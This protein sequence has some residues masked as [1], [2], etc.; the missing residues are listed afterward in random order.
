[1]SIFSEASNYAG[2]PVEEQDKIAKELVAKG[3]KVIKL[4]RGDPAVYF[5]T[6]KYI[7][8]AYIKAL[9]EGKSQYEY[10]Y[11]AQELRDAVAQRYRKMYNLDLN[12]EED[13]IVT[14]GVSESLIFL[15]SVLMDK[16]GIR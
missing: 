9:R 6:P 1:M 4:S 10:F 15:N 7:I 11:G 16:G 12:V 13:I 5:K 8:D 2:N 3:R 14:N